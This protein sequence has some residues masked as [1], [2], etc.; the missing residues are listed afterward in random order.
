MAKPLMADLYLCFGVNGIN[1]PMDHV[2]AR[3]MK[4]EKENKVVLREIG[5]KGKWN[6]KSKMAFKPTYKGLTEIMVFYDKDSGLQLD[7]TEVMKGELFSRP[8][9][10]NAIS[11]QITAERRLKTRNGM[12]VQS[13]LFTGIAIMI[14]LS[15]VFIM[16]GMILFANSLSHVNYTI[17]I[18]NSSY[19]PTSVGAYNSLEAIAN[20]LA[21]P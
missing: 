4:D 1:T 9:I 5:G 11:D 19:K 15:A 8:D 7:P 12:D 10:K 16:I 14:L 21:N 20:T 3:F 17:Q 2:K 6:F 18:V 13:K